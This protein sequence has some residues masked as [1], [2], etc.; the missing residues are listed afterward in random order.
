MDGV[1][2]G[3]EG[4]AAR[5]EGEGEPGVVAK[6]ELEGLEGGGDAGFAEGFEE[7]DDGDVEGV[8]EGLFGGDPTFV[9]VVVVGGGVVFVAEGRIE[10]EGVGGEEATL[11]GGGVEEGFENATCTA[12]AA[13]GINLSGFGVV[14]VEGAEIDDGTGGRVAIE[15]NACGV[16]DV[17][18]AVALLAEEGEDVALPIGAEGVAGLD[19]VEVFVGFCD[20]LEACGLGIVATADAGIVEDGV[21]F[22]SGECSAANHHL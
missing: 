16:V 14:K 12:D 15:N 2:E 17:G 7:T 1:D 4:C 5:A 11:D 10:E 22:R 19:G 18:E 21:G 3:V 20:A 6:G 13:C 9:A 8:C